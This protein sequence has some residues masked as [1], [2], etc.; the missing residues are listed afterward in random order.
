MHDSD[1]RQR[2]TG[3]PPADTGGGVA[4]AFGFIF[5][6]EW[7]SDSASAVPQATTPLCRCQLGPSTLNFGPPG[8]QNGWAQLGLLLDHGS[9]YTVRAF[10]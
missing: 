7:P 5:F 3:V 1:H 10:A 6:L 4:S 2:G 9:S 8:I